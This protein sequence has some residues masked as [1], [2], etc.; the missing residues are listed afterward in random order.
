MFNFTSKEIWTQL[1]VWTEWTEQLQRK[2]GFVRPLR[3]VKV[4]P[5]AALV[6][7]RRLRKGSSLI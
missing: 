1:K 3:R 6:G 2:P 5:P 4:E 7:V